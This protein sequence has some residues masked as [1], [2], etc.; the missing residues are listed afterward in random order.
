MGLREDKFWEKFCSAA[1]SSLFP[2]IFEFLGILLL[3]SFTDVDNNP[4]FL[5][6]VA[7]LSAICMMMSYLIYYKILPK[8]KKLRELGKY[9]GRWL[10]IIPEFSER[11]CSIIDFTYNTASL[12]YEM[13]GFNFTKDLK[14]GVEFKAFK[15]V[16]RTFRDGFYF[17]TN[18][19]SEHK[20]GLG[21]IAFVKSNFDNMTRAIGYFFDSSYDNCSRKYDTIL[22]KC[23]KYFYEHLGPQYRHINADEMTPIEIAE[24]SQ[25]LIN[26]EINKY[27]VNKAAH[28]RQKGKCDVCPHTNFDSRVKV[29]EE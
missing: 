14:S 9:E 19:T 29:N 13:L 17:I 18:H 4:L 26:D 1:L 23:D 24:I 7:I 12:K 16:E 5:A 20:N 2:A 11:P 15:F 25:S 6:L 3:D 21:K 10:Q 8:F 27:L 22:I 28:A